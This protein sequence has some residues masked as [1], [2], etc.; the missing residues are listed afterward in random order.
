MSEGLK[1]T[2]KRMNKFGNHCFVESNDDNGVPVQDL[3]QD[4]FWTIENPSQL[5][6]DYFPHNKVRIYNN[7]NYLLSNKA[8]EN[9]PTDT[10]RFGCACV[11]YFTHKDKKYFIN[12]VDNKPYFQNPQG[13]SNEGET[14]IETGIRELSEELKIFVDKEQFVEAG[15]WTFSDYNALVDTTFEVTTIF[16]SLNLSYSKVEHLITRDLSENQ[17]N[18][19]NVNEYDFELDET[20]YVIIIPED[21]LLDSETE[22][23]LMKKDKLT[24]HTFS[25]HHRNIM[26]NVINKDYAFHYAHSYLKEFRYV[27]S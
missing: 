16:Y 14:A 13:G 24:R 25:G 2:S 10:T 19:F 8:S 3:S 27:S 5:L 26:M 18:I 20:Q 9:I 1:L 12:V 6:I 7:I 21:I 11:V 23:N 15:Y 17:L 22:I 4:D